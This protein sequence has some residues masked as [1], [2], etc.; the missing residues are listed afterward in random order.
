MAWRYVSWCGSA[1]CDHWRQ[2]ARISPQAAVSVQLLLIGGFGQALITY[3]SLRAL[4]YI[5]VG[6]LAFLFL[7][8]SR[9]GRIACGDATN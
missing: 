9:V 7:Y 2:A 8:L 3:L 1:P 5:P 4:E 6:P